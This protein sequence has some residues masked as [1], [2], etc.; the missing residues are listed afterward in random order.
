MGDFSDPIN[1][2]KGDLEDLRMDIDLKEKDL[3]KVKNSLKEFE[4]QKELLEAE[5]DELKDQEV[6]AM[7]EVEKIE[8]DN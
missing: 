1:R 3:K 5:I 4:R 2:L 6:R 7:K 8:M